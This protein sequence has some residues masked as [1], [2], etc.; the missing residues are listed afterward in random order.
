MRALPILLFA[1]LAACKPPP[2]DADMRR[3][4][5]EAAPSFASDPLPSPESEGALWAPSREVE[6]RLIYGQVGAAPLLALE[7]LESEG[8][9][10]SLRITRY[11]DADVDATALLALI[12]NGHIGR[13]PV[14][15]REVG[16]RIRWQG[17]V[18]ASDLRWEPLAGPRRVTVTVPGA[19]MVTINPSGL[20]GDLVEQCR[21]S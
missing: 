3:D 7:C 2:T 13:L 14:E 8:S 6:G 4:M 9:A 21:G 16:G 17:E 10:P 19:G 12:G 5:P 15:A 11:A 1:A 20:T 18:L